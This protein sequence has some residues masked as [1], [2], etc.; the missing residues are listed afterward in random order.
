MF[1]QVLG[2]ERQYL[3]IGVNSLFALC[4]ALQRLSLNIG[5]G[6][7]LKIHDAT[8]YSFCRVITACLLPVTL[9]RG[10]QKGTNVKLTGF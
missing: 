4:R 2:K 8:V 6:I 9:V 1:W 7:E 3:V 5:S 10:H